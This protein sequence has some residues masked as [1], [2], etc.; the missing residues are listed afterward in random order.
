MKSA[1]NDVPA[2]DERIAIRHEGDGRAECSLWWSRTPH[3]DGRRVG[4]IGHYLRTDADAARKMLTQARTTLRAAGCTLAIG[5]VDGSTWD[6][7]RFVTAFGSRGPFMFEPMNPPEYPQ[8]FRDAGFHVRARYVSAEETG[9]LPCDLRADRARASLAMRGVA[10]RD[11]DLARFN[12][13][14][15]A[16]YDVTNAGFDK[17]LL[18][19]PISREAFHARYRPL[20]AAIDPALVRIAHCEGRTVGFAFAFADGAPSH[21]TETC[22]S[23]VLKTLARLPGARFAGLG[24][25]L[26]AD[27]RDVARTRGYRRLVHALMRDDNDSLRTSR[28]CAYV[29][30]EYALFAS[31]LT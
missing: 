10:V 20:Q 29:F 3:L 13:E 11:F 1:T 21:D 28:R 5:P 27:V 26:L 23:I 25:V 24:T 12:E 6:R 18:F 15:D 7:Y 31:D 19:S 30:R 16:L 2:C 22:E 9:S 4:Y 14:I 8:D 17:S